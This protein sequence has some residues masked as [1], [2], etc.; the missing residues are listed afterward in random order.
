MDT[1]VSLDGICYLF[2]TQAGKTR[3]KVLSETTPTTDTVPVGI[4]LP[5]AWLI[6]RKDGTPLF[7]IRPD[8]CERPFRIMTAEQLYAEKIQWFEP[9]ADNHREL[10]WNNPDAKTAGSQAYGAYK[11]HSWQSIIEFAI[12]DRFS[13]SFH[14]DLPGDWKSSKSGGNGYLMVMVGGTPYWTDAIGQIPFSVDTFKMYCEELG[15]E[16]SAIDRTVQTGIEW[17]DGMVG[18]KQDKSNEYDNFMILRA[19]LWAAENH[20]IRKTSR[21]IRQRGGSFKKTIIEVVYT[22]A[23]SARLEKPISQESLNR[24]GHWK[25]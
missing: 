11:H 9:L 2:E 23:S 6:T 22:P 5:H 20:Q 17:G 10:I 3:L 16:N 8:E 19:A 24:H 25:R 12:V 1:V 14:S 13:L 7:A 18:G 21:E 4:N 15:D